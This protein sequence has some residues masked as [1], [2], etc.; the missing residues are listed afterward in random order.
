MVGGGR[1]EEE[2]DEGDGVAGGLGGRA[3]R[4]YGRDGGGGCNTATELQRIFL[5][6][7]GKRK[8]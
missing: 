6:N 8:L 7:L 4:A 5:P 3:A 1:A 2:E